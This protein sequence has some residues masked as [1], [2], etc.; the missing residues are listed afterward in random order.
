MK[1]LSLVWGSG[2]DKGPIQMSKINTLNQSNILRTCS[3]CDGFIP[4]NYNLQGQADPQGP[5]TPAL[6]W[7]NADRPFQLILWS[8]GD[9]CARVQMSAAPKVALVHDNA[10]ISVEDNDVEE[11]WGPWWF[12]AGVYA[13]D[14]WQ[15]TAEQSAAYALSFAMLQNQLPIALI[16]TA[17]AFTQ[18]GLVASLKISN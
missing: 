12:E 5:F 3:C 6:R 2:V 1:N 18:E 15:K 10:I 17:L 16:P 11:V 14:A 4:A 13:F 8:V 9:M 7:V